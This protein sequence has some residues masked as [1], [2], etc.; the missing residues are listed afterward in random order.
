MKAGYEV[1]AYPTQAT[2]GCVKAV[3]ERQG[4]YDMVACCGGDGTL[5]EVVNGMMQ[6]E[7]KLP[8]GYIPAGSTNDLQAVSIYPKY[9]EGGGDY[10]KRQRLCL[11]YRSF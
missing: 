10:R 3:K 2:G 7:E 11:R 8:V 6:S 1:T 9:G 5:D 4:S